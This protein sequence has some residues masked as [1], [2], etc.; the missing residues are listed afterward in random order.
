MYEAIGEDN[1]SDFNEAKKQFISDYKY[2][3]LISQQVKN[4]K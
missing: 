2:A 4:F 3:Q 1:L